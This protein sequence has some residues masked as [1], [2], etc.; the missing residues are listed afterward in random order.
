V[1]D[2]TRR[3]LVT[4]LV[5]FGALVLFGPAAG[6]AVLIATTLVVETLGASAGAGTPAGLVAFVLAVAAGLAV[7]TEAAAVR[8]GGFVALDRGT[9]RERV[10]RYGTLLAVGAAA[11]V[12]VGSFLAEVSAWAVRNGREEYLVLLAAVGVAIAWVVVRTALA[13]RRGWQARR[14]DPLA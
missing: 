11:V 2:T 7:A 5:L 13:F 6:V 3:Y 12:A 1:N 8:L 4:G 9:D 14:P 10:V